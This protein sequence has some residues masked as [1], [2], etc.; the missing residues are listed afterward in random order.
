[1]QKLHVKSVPG[2]QFFIQHCVSVF[3]ITEDRMSHIG[4]M[5]TDLMRASCQK[6]DLQKRLLPIVCK[7]TIF[8][9]DWSSILCLVFENSDLVG[10]FVFQKPSSDILFFFDHA[11]YNTK[12]IFVQGT[13]FEKPGEYLQTLQRLARCHDSAR[14]AVQTV[15]Q[16]R[17]ECF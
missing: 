9:V 10:L 12:V 3:R 17:P 7:R 13:F 14:I 15:A 11:F 6:L 5:G 8:C 1:M 2:S 4:Q 16:G